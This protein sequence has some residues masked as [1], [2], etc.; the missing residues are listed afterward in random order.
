MFDS[1]MDAN[2]LTTFGGLVT[3]VMLIVQF[4]KEFI[5]LKFGDSY[6][7]VFSLLVA[8]VLTFV[9]A[10]GEWNIPGIALKVINGIMVSIASGGAYEIITDP[11]AQK[12]FKDQIK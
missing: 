10:P 12:V 1:F 11:K 2:A 6:V 8:L 7:R 4:S 3:A 9:F 5:K